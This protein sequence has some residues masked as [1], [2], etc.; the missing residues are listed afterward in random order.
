MVTG[1]REAGEA[2]VAADGV[3]MVAMTG[4]T[5]AG[6]RIL[7]VAART[8]KKVHLELGGNDATIVCED[9]DVAATAEALV[10][11]PLH[12]R[13]R[14]DLLRGQ[15]GAGAPLGLCPAPR[16]GGGADRA[17]SGSATRWTRRPTSAR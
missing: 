6:R 4:S 10:A 2:L 14:A 5:A 12:L 3:Q 8:L 9:A 1:G 15:A 13:Q 11:G 16:G 17:A 7:E